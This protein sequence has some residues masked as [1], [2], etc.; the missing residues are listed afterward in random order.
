MSG[1]ADFAVSYPRGR[2]DVREMHA[3]SGVPVA[4]ILAITHT[5]GF[6]ALADGEQA[7]ELALAA[8]RE[9][10]GR[11]PVD[12]DEIRY[13]VVAGSGQWDRP[14]WSPAAKVAHELGI[15]RAHCFEV[16]NF[17]NAGMAAL[18]IVADRIELDGG[19]YG[20]VLVG[21]R[22]S[23][24]VDYTD[25]ASKALFNFGDAAGA[26]LVEPGRG[27][28]TV[29]H[30]EMRTDPSWSDY[31][32][33][34]HRGDRVAIRRAAHRSGLAAAYVENFT[35][36]ISRTLDAVGAKL[37]DVAHLLINQGDRDMH[38]RLLRELD[39]PAEKSVF[40]YHRFGHMGG[41][42]TLI[43]LQDLREQRKLRSGD[44]IILAT[45]AMGFS[46][47][48]TALEYHE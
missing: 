8:A 33:G 14:F 46:W 28:F 47:G 24:M 38:E 40:N 41:T 42:D 10:L 30:S 48:I 12:V 17:C 29:L 31:Y 23:R 15:G 6:P 3:A 34:E 7:W 35:A 37:P 4:D 9:L 44:L 16:A 22:L 18:K 39:L 25:P 45:S 32:A 27:A 26:M 21:D 43:A 13:V 5:E 36:L 2:A 1:I 19:G 11:H 20:L